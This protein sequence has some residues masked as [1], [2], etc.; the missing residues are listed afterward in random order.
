MA[1]V[2]IVRTCKLAAVA[3]VTLRVIHR[4]FPQVLRET[5]NFLF[6][7]AGLRVEIRTRDLLYANHEYQIIYYKETTLVHSIMYNK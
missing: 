4:T 6:T 1:A 3:C 2:V 7:T 5:R